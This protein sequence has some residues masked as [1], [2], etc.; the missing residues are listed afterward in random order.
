MKTI[1]WNELKGPRP[2]CS[3]IGF[4]FDERGRFPILYRSNKVRSAKN[5]WSL[6]SGLHEVG[7]NIFE[8]FA[9]EAKE[10]CNL[11][12]IKGSGFKIGYYEPIIKKE[13]WHWIMLL[14]GMQ[15]KSLDPLINMEPE[16]HSSI[17]IVTS[18]DLY[19]WRLHDKW[20]Q[21]TREALLEYQTII[22]KVI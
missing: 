20:T 21:G 3:V 4:A 2:Y 6:V 9:K 22:Q 11:E 7:N 5:A 19:K 10:E 16:K 8:Q 14:V 17:N 18:F 12:M 13:R 1:K 15:V